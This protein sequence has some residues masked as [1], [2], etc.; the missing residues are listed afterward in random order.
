M[1]NEI[2]NFISEYSLIIFCVIFLILFFRR[3]KKKSFDKS[4]HTLIENFTF[5]RDTFYNMVEVELK[6]HGVQSSIK[7]TKVSGSPTS[8]T[9]NTYLQSK[10]NG[11]TFLI[12]A[13]QFGDDHFGVSYWM[14]KK[15][16]FGEWLVSRL[17]LGSK[18]AQWMFRPRIPQIDIYTSYLTFVDKSVK[19]VVDEITDEYEGGE[20]N[21]VSLSATQGFDPFM[22]VNA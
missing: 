19:K 6:A 5:S 17:P 15:V 22:R 9:S 13:H 18:L 20:P 7:T 21:V 11:Y 8:S 1:L 14:Y 12:G 4:W 3:Y 10:Y 16:G 2:I